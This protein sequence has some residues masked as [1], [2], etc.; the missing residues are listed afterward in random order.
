MTSETQVPHDLSAC[1]YCGRLLA[2]GATF[3]RSWHVGLTL[4]A[5]RPVTC[6]MTERYLELQRE[7][8]RAAA[9]QQAA[10]AA[11]QT[12]GPINID[13]GARR[14]PPP[15]PGGGPPRTIPL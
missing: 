14:G 7:R 2:P 5:E 13:P 6:C 15:T 3:E 4:G 10:A 9:Q 11:A 8:E 12:S 1:P